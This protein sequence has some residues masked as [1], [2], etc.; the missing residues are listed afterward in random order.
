MSDPRER[1]V[2]V[3][4]SSVSSVPLGLVHPGERE[5][6]SKR[7]RM[8]PHRPLTID[9]REQK[10]SRGRERSRVDQIRPLWDGPGQKEQQVMWF[11][12]SLTWS[13][14]W[15]KGGRIGEMLKESEPPE[16]FLAW[17]VVKAQ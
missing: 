2:Q 8:E 14:W 17:P 7:A 1:E 3:L 9:T 11:P 13:G 15:V 10:V 12:L 5:S 6:S 4:G 16:F